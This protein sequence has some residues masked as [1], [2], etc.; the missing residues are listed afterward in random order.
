M[1]RGKLTDAAGGTSPKDPNSRSLAAECMLLSA[2]A[3]S[4][5]PREQSIRYDLC[6]AYQGC[7]GNNRICKVQRRVELGWGHGEK[8]IEPPAILALVT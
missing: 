4:E 8:Q 5:C 7:L 3:V 1:F 2:P 6:L